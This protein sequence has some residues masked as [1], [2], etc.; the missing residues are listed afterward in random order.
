VLGILESK[1]LMR[2]CLSAANVDLTSSIA[3]PLYVPNSITSMMLLETFKK[4]R[5]HVALVVDEYGEVQ[6]LVTMNDVLEA[7]VGNIPSAEAPG[8]EEAVRREDGSW[9]LDGMLSIA[10]F[11]EIFELESMEEEE[12][13]NFHTL[14]GFVMLRLGRVPAVGDHFEWNGLRLEVVDMD[15]HRV[16]RILAARLPASPAPPPQP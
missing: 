4:T 1:T 3:K 8:D 9:L 16:D 15:R 13:G 10:K 7:I 11:K 6:G 2:Q 5:T 14:G 12:A